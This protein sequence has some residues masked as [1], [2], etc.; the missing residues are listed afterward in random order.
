MGQTGPDPG[1]SANLY[2]Y[3]LTFLSWMG[4]E[5]PAWAPWLFAAL[6]VA[7]MLLSLAPIVRGATAAVRYAK[8]WL[9]RRRD[10]RRARRRALFAD[11]IE[12][13]LRRLDEKEEW[14]DHRF[15]RLEA[16]VEMEGGRSRFLPRWAYSRRNDLR[17]EKSLSRALQ[18][19]NE[20]LVIL[21]GEPGS[22]KSV[23]LR[24]AARALAT[25]AMRR[26]RLDSRIPLYVNLKELRPIDSRLDAGT[27]R[28]YVLDQ[29]NK[30]NSRDVEQ[31]LSD[32]FTP[33][34]RDGTWLFL[35]DSFD[36]I[37]EVLTATELDATVGLYADALYDFLHGMNISA[38]VVASREFKG[39]RRFGWPRFT[40]QRLTER[41]K[42]EL[43][44]KADLAAAAEAQVHGALASADPMVT[45]LSGNPMLLG[46]L[47][48]HVR[49]TGSFPT[50]SH[51]IFETFVQNRLE[52]D[53]ERLLRRYAVDPNELRLVA[54]EIAFH[55]TA[56]S[57][58]GLSP[59][60][61][62]VARLL[63]GRHIAGQ[64][65]NPVRL[66]RLLDAL[67]YVKL[68]QAPEG[69][70]SDYRRP[71]TF[72]HRRFQEYF[73]TCVVIREPDRIPI[74]TL[75]LDGRW[76]ETAVA[77]LQTQAGEA[78]AV[79]V[80]AA[81]R[82]L[83]RRAETAGAASSPVTTSPNEP[84]TSEWPPNSLHLLDLL[85]TGLAGR[86][87]NVPDSLR[88]TVTTLL[89]A[90][91][92]T[93]RRHYQLWTVQA[94]L[95]AEPS[96]A[97]EIL[98][99][100]FAS[101]SAL[102]R[103]AAYRYA[104]R[105][106]TLPP[107]LGRHM[108]MAMINQ[109]A[110]GHL[111][112]DWPTVRA[113][114]S[115]L[116]EP[117][118]ELR[119]A[120]LLRWNPVVTGLLVTLVFVSGAI[121]QGSGGRIGWA[122]GWLTSISIVGAFW[123]AGIGLERAYA[124]TAPANTWAGDALFQSAVRLVA[125]LLGIGIALDTPSGTPKSGEGPWIWGLLFLVASFYAVVWPLT[126]VAA[127]AWGID[128]RIFFWPFLPLAFMPAAVMT[129][130]RIGWR[131]RIE[132]IGRVV[133]MVAGLTL[134]LKA[135]LWLETSHPRAAIVVTW[136]LYCLTGVLG[137]MIIT[138]YMIRERGDRRYL[139]A[140]P[141]QSVIDAQT[142]DQM[143]ARLRSDRGL[144]L[145]VDMIRRQ[146]IDCTAESMLI[147]DELILLAARRRTEATSLP[148]WHRQLTNLRWNRWARPSTGYMS[149]ET[150]DELAR[151]ISERSELALNTKHAQPA[152]NRQ[153]DSSQDHLGSVGEVT[154]KE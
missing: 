87:E 148:F 41:Q 80:S 139:L 89:R 2:Q 38:G 129:S 88:A 30:A 14:R 91:W 85:D 101:K 63:D 29:L 13:Q 135:S 65:I 25:R 110:Q 143:I 114:L 147:F 28:T 124:R 48:E 56:E 36:E 104:G 43:I 149:E 11:H 33:G 3:F 4:L 76:R 35:F 70:R 106:P 118:S 19:S 107:R 109:A 26:P 82:I 57:G 66:D 146:R 55:L 150:L 137:A 73:A 68:A 23:A 79:M 151:L 154:I 9:D 69:S 132:T 50:A 15:A 103:G 133:A 94:T 49:T 140:T 60:R 61:A 58:I 5:H 90:A 52:R 40:V 138:I 16:E 108:R 121:F 111:L 141:P 54:E 97:E 51:T 125:V 31:F 112:F 34:M 116:N 64:L 67:E 98:E 126:A 1:G 7:G 136:I 59:S 21:Q 62:E 134:S 46:L 37:P 122:T 77:M 84:P 120:R 32:E 93:R 99:E 12:S 24:N 22:G 142:L 105:L 74:E 113:Q 75:L 145:L 18:R 8:G 119:A 130:P 144:R 153:R 27:I 47:C 83:T 17:R 81:G 128:A 39:P 71:F 53:Q 123:G 96:A 42:R 20:R 117:L 100:S 10:P 78:V 115:R 72:A 152:L 92:A 131:Q 45:R 102:L 95:L 44:R 6:I 127:V 86:P